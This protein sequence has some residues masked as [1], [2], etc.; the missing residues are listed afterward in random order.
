MGSIS[1]AVILAF[2]DEVIVLLPVIIKTGAD[3]AKL[4]SSIENVWAEAK[5]DSNDPRFAEVQAGIAVARAALKA[6]AAVLNAG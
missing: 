3:V 5:I 4:I 6:R 2:I 1:A